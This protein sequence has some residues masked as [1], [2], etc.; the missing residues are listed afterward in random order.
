MPELP[1]VERATALIRRA[2]V[3][4]ADTPPVCAAVPL[5]TDAL[6]IYF[7]LTRRPRR[8][9][10]APYLMP[11]DTVKPFSSVAAFSGMKATRQ[12]NISIGR[13]PVLHFGMTGMLKVKGRPTPQYKSKLGDSSDGWPPRFVKACYYLLPHSPLISARG[14]LQFIL[15]I[16]ESDSGFTELA[17]CDA[18]RLG[19]IRMAFSPL[20]EPPISDLGFDPILS[21]PSLRDFRNTVSKRTC[22]IKALLLDQSFSAGI[23]N[24][25]ADEILYQAQVHPEQRCNTLDES[26]T[27]ALHYQISDMCR[28][29]VEANADDAKYPV[30]WLFHHRW[31]KG[32]KVKQ[33]M[34]LVVLHLSASHHELIP[35][36]SQPSGEPAAIKWIVVGGRTSAY[37]PQVQKP[38]LKLKSHDEPPE[39]VSLITSIDE[40]Q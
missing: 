38:L 26:Q 5:T 12:E 23:G 31:G 10:V 11:L 24:Y 33:L 17:F 15:F 22:P 36:I 13:M 3:R 32:K 16:Q 4:R 21:M 19:R 20:A 35:R 39:V 37:I 6:G 29:T 40:L 25:L 14:S 8:L 9:L 2:R 28:I 18:R 34:K 27:L 7:W 1:E 30:H